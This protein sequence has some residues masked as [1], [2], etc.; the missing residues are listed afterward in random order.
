MTKT[1]IKIFLAAALAAAAAPALAQ[2]SVDVSAT[3]RTGA[4]TG[5]SAGVQGSVRET[6]KAR[7]DQEIDRRVT[8]LNNFLARV[9]AMTKIDASFKASL[10]STIQ[11]QINDLTSLKATIDADEGTTTLRMEV[12]SITKAY[13][14]YALV[15]PQAAIGA[16]ADR[17]QTM[18]GMFQTLG[19]KLQARLSAASSTGAAAASAMTDFNAKVADAQVQATAAITHISGLQPDNGDKAVM[20]SN[21]DALKKARADIK[22]AMEDFADARKDAA[23]VMSALRIGASAGAGATLQA[24]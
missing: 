3:V 22:V 1:L 18:V 10:T 16:A 23:T 12:Q 4:G 14:I 9:N 7:A 20:K 13:R 24:Q 15:L 11:G 19:S 17:V 5:V 21:T 2:T 6:A 8:S